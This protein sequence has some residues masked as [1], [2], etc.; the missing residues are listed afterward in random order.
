MLS[1]AAALSLGAS[2]ATAGDIYARYFA[3]ADRGKPCYARS[4][5]AAHLLAHPKQKVRR[6][7]VDFDK[8][9][10]EGVGA[11]NSAAKF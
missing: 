3:G 7:E 8:N 4:Y 5:D 2:A 10:G 11:K 1:C 9:V 6:I